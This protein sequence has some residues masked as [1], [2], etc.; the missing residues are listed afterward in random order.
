MRGTNTAELND[1]PP[2]GCTIALPGAD[3]ITIEGDHIR[4]VQGYF[5]QRTFVEQL[6]LQVIVQPHEL[7]GITFGSSGRLASERRTK[8]G[9]VSLT[10]IEVQSDEEV[11]EV[12]ERALQVLEDMKQM[13][14]FISHVGVTLG[15][16]LCT[17]TAWADPEAPHQLQRGGTH[18]EAMKRAF[19]PDFS[20][21]FHTGVYVPHHTNP[22]WIGSL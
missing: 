14:G 16:R 15:Q 9:A 6:G 2:T 4:A 10:W 20:T 19:G 1:S 5:D 17:V 13:P 8:P 3:F 7:A 12:R 22:L 21:V 18:E 11:Q